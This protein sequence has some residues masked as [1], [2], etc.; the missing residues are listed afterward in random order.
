MPAMRVNNL[1]LGWQSAPSRSNRLRA[2]NSAE[3]HSCEE[4]AHALTGW[5]NDVFVGARTEAA[6]YFKYFS[7]GFFYY[8]HLKGS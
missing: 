6:W 5:F 7:G 1:T 4:F 8:C 2:E 3:L